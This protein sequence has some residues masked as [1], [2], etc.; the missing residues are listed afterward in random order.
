MNKRNLI[1]VIL[2]LVVSLACGSVASITPTHQPSSPTPI[3]SPLSRA[4]AE[5]KLVPPTVPDGFI[6]ETEESVGIT[7]ARPSNWEREIGIRDLPVSGAPVDFVVYYHTEPDTIKMISVQTLG[8]YHPY[9]SDSDFLI[10]IL[11]A[12]PEKVS[13]LNLKVLDFADSTIVATHPAQALS[14]RLDDQRSGLP[15]F[16]IILILATPDNTAIFLQWVA[17]ESMQKET[18]ELFIK[19]LPTVSLLP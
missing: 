6:V 2:A 10:G 9:Q 19:M 18:T 3:D 11:G 13:E 12:N 17:N 5:S 14:Y 4:I 1:A 8:I 16:S 7:I 15:L